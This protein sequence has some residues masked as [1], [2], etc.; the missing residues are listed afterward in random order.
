MFQKLFSELQQSVKQKYVFFFILFLA[1]NSVHIY[2]VSKKTWTFFEIGII[3]LFI[4]ESLQNFVWLK[5]NDSSL[6]S[7]EDSVNNNTSTAS[8]VTMTSNFICVIILF[9]SALLQP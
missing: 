3:P 2:G 6:C 7:G 8:D 5:Q 1:V 4:K 9:S